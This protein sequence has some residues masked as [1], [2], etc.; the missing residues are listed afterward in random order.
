MRKKYKVIILST[1][2]ENAPLTLR[3]NCFGECTGILKL[4]SKADGRDKPQHL[5]II[6]DEKIKVGDWTVDYDCGF[7]HGRLTTIDNELELKRYAENPKFNIKKVIATTDPKCKTRTLGVRSPSV[8]IPQIPKSFV[9]D[10]EINPVEEIELEHEHYSLGGEDES[11]AI[12]INKL[13]IVE[14][15][16]VVASVKD[17]YSREEVE[18]IVLRYRAYT[19]KE[20]V[21]LIDCENWLKENL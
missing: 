16:V 5:Y 2:D 3:N 17:S 9:K 8:P 1:E 11:K 15:K 13:K 7:S 10:Y 20:G 19:W 12:V 21:R 18:D 4:L 6:S 14:N